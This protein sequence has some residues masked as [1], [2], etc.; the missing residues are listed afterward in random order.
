M[1]GGGE[2]NDAFNQA[3]HTHHKATEAAGEHGDE[4]HDDA[5]F[6]VTEHELV[7]AQR[8]EKQPQQPRDQF[9]VGDFGIGQFGHW[10]QSTRTLFSGVWG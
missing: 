2:I 7:Y 9:L 4:Q 3:D 1:G 5:G 8:T 10:G 6:G